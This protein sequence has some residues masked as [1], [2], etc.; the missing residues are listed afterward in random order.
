M[1][2]STC[3]NL[4]A[5]DVCAPVG[6]KAPGRVRRVPASPGRL[7]LLGVEW[8]AGYQ[9]AN[10]GG[11]RGTQVPQNGVSAHVWNQGLT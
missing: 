11:V 6:C 2:K 3:T 8:G 9:E 10:L 4:F 5:F 7:K 1:Y